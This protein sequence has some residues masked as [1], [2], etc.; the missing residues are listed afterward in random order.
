MSQLPKVELRLVRVRMLR[1]K[2]K[3]PLSDKPYIYNT[4][5]VYCLEIL[6]VGLF[7][8]RCLSC[9]S[10]LTTPEYWRVKNNNDNCNKYYIF[11]RVKYSCYCYELTS[12]NLTPHDVLDRSSP[13]S[14]D[15]TPS[16][17]R[18]GD[19]DTERD[20]RSAAPTA[21]TPSSSACRRVSAASTGAMCSCPPE[22]TDDVDDRLA[23]AASDTTC[24][25][26]AADLCGVYHPT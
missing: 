5:A 13:E 16:L 19:W 14:R 17:L 22:P 7:L 3:I 8:K 9:R 25:R 20:R 26:Y 4:L 18:W 2:I 12:A 6:V 11:C 1:S 15:S 24:S 10:R 21:S 23:V